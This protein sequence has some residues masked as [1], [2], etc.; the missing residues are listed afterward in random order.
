M[1]RFFL[2][3]ITIFFILNTNS[4]HSQANIN[5]TFTNIVI[6]QSPRDL[7]I[8]E[9][10]NIKSQKIILEKLSSKVTLINFWATWCAPCKKELPLL[11]KLANSVN[12]KQLNIVLIN[13]ENKKYSDVKS[14]LDNLGIKNLTTYFDKNLKLTRSLGLRGVPVTLVVNSEKKEVARILGDIDF[15]NEEFVNWIKSF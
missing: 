9:I 3:F 12:S 14:F 6:H 4:I 5:K 13:L 8:L 10:E 2:F 15:N 1:F 11:D 7:P